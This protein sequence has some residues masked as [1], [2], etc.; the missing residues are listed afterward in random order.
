MSRTTPTKPRRHLDVPV[1]DV[2]Y[3]NG[4]RCQ[5]A[6][7]GCALQRHCQR[8]WSLRRM[9]H[10]LRPGLLIVGSATV[11]QEAGPGPW[12]PWCTVVGLHQKIAADLLAQSPWRPPDGDVKFESWKKYLPQLWNRAQEQTGGL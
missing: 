7:A 6:D 1:T 2:V 8:F 5:A 4:A 10:D 11:L 12:P 9:V 3:T